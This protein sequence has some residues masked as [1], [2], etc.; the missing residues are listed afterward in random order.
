MPDEPVVKTDTSAPAAPPVSPSP[1]PAATEPPPSTPSQ[2]S[3]PH[4]E[5]KSWDQMKPLFD[6][7]DK[8]GPKGPLTQKP[9]AKPT[10]VPPK[11]QTSTTP[12]APAAPAS[13][14]TRPATTPSGDPVQEL[15]SAEPPSDLTE[16]SKI[17]WKEFKEKWH[18]LYQS[19]QGKL[20]ELQK[21][22]A[23]REGLTKKE[24]AELEEK[25]KTL[26]KYEYAFDYQTDP[27][28]QTKYIQPANKLWGE[29][30]ATLKKAGLNEND[31]NSIDFD[32]EIA[33]EAFAMQLQEKYGAPVANVF[34][35]KANEFRGVRMSFN[36]ARQNAVTNY[37]TIL[38]EK[39]E[40][41]KLKENEREGTIRKTLDSVFAEK[42]EDGSPRWGY[43]TEKTSEPGADQATQEAVAQHN[44]FVKQSRE[45]IEAL[46]R[47]Q[48]PAEISKM[49]V[50]AE[51]G[52]ILSHE[53]PIL[54]QQIKALEDE[55][56]K[57]QG[58][59]TQPASAPTTP[60]TSPQRYVRG[61]STADEFSKLARR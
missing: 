26:Q 5:G 48:D 8:S 49:A 16:A 43:F 6:K 2:P 52:L 31:I 20:G 44:Q 28:F 55:L 57:I 56:A 37:D 34:R 58:G 51:V 32:D 59:R 3:S 61:K 29:L 21:Q 35:Q 25:I 27:E 14:S 46:S 33:T 60:V 12:P 13:P 15:L 4:R 17:G 24:K 50:A 42:N 36:E 10:S 38:K 45:R 18:G 9:Q 39:T 54:L 19:V 1:A 11:V 47:V 41:R 22:L 23:D 53:R 30:N 40:A 7:R